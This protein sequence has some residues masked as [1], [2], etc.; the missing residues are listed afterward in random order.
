MPP[1]RIATEPDLWIG[2]RDDSLNRQWLEAHNIKCV[3]NCT[4]DLLFRPNA[5]IV[6]KIRLPLHDD[7]KDVDKMTRLL[8][9]VVKQLAAAR[10][11][12]YNVLVHCRA[13]QQRSAC[14]V[15][16]YIMY[17]SKRNGVQ[18]VRET[19]AVEFVREHRKQ[20][21]QPRVNFRRS[22]SS[23]SRQL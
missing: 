13:G 11:A 14:V 10:D 2:N 3:I 8:P 20:A 19:H 5:G 17:Q 23:Y 6:K 15:A 16:A 18:W 7:P 22:L 9:S 4:P 12:G 21:F 1:N